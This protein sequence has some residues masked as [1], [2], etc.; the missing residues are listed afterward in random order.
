MIYT[1][2]INGLLVQTGDIICTTD[3][4][5]GII[6]GEFW[7]LIGKLVPGAVD[8]IVIYVGPRGRCVEAGAKGVITFEVEGNTW[9]AREMTEQRGPLIDTFYGVAYPLGGKG[10]SEEGD[11]FVIPLSCVYDLQNLV[12]G[13]NY[14][15]KRHVEAQVQCL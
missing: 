9:V 8:H 2:R 12:S 1:Y 10:Y 11:P 13:S 7:R 15:I 4:E 3:G 6:P 5:R 14:P